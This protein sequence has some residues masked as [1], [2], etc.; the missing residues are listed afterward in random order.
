MIYSELVSI[1]LTI[2]YFSG[3]HML[4]AILR[5]YMTGYISPVARPHI[6]SE[7]CNAW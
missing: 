2:M 5:I 4:G 1:E 3:K 7:A 6:F